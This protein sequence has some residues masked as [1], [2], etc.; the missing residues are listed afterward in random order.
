MSTIYKMHLNQKTTD[1]AI[2]S[3]FCVGY[4]GR[5]KQQ[6]LK[7]VEEL[8]ELG[9]PKPQEIPALFPL[10]NS[11]VTHDS[12]IEVIGGE[13][14]GEAE[15]VFIFGD[16]VDEVYVTVGSDHTD[17][18]LETVDINKSKQVC[19]K[20]FAKRA[21][22]LDDL[23]NHWDELE[24]ASYILVNQQWEPYQRESVQ[25]ILHPTDV[26]EFLKK[27]QIPLK[28]SIVFAG[29]VPLLNGFKQGSK[30]LMKLIDPVKNDEISTEYEIKNL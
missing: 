10:R 16:S 5:D 7:H 19:D 6:A 3:C 18:S 15:I 23:L 11:S 17:R 24:L 8:A 9:V 14:T 26:I 4:S 12:M 30:F 13:S 21:W 28:H 29:T 27:K 2:N 22:L 20:P 25:K 1:L